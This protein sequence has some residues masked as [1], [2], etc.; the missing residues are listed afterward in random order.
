VRTPTLFSNVDYSYIQHVACT[1]YA[2]Y[3]CTRQCSSKEVRKHPAA[4]LRCAIYLAQVV[5]LRF[6]VLAQRI[7]PDYPLGSS[8]ATGPLG[9]NPSVPQGPLSIV[10]WVAPLGSPPFYRLSA[11]GSALRD[12]ELGDLSEHQA[13]KSA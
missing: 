8:V 13:P 4:T 9:S 11:V 6:P 12:L 2:L 7:T 3:L 1:S 5:T 10:C